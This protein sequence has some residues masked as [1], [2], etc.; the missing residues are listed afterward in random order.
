M[1]GMTVTTPPTMTQAER[2]RACEAVRT[3]LHSERA[4]DLYW[5][6]EYGREHDPAINDGIVDAVL[7]AFAEQCAT[8]RIAVVEEAAQVAEGRDDDDPDAGE[9]MKIDERGEN[10]H[11]E[12]SYGIGRSDAAAAIR[13]FLKEHNHVE[14]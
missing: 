7:T 6:A 14:G 13:A 2:A 4:D 1:G 12:S 8:D 3:F 11:R 9:D 10:W 5:S